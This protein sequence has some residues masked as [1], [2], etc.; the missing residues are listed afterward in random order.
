M[1]SQIGVLPFGTTGPYSAPGKISVLNVVALAENRFVVAWD[2]PPNVD[3]PRGTRSAINVKN[4]TIA[5]VDPTIETNDGPIVPPGELV[6]TF[7]V[8]LW[9]AE[10]DEVDATQIHVWTDRV[11]EGGRRYTLTI[12]G[13]IDGAANCEEFIGDLDWTFRAPSPPRRREENPARILDLEDVDDGLI[14][15]GE[16]SAIWHYTTAGD[17]DMQSSVDALRKRITRMLSSR[18]GEWTYDPS[19]GVRVSLKAIMRQDELQASCNSIKE[20]LVADPKV[21]AVFVQA[22]PRAVGGG[23]VVEYSINV[24]LATGTTVALSIPVTVQES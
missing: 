4:Y 23:V 1:I 15:G 9:R 11:M 16:T 24:G 8:G 21:A 13:P 19:F 7:E 20:T 17:F 14:P 5:S 2:V 18:K 22:R 12:D 3:D 10:V 6:P